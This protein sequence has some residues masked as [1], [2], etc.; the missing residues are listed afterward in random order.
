[1]HLVCLKSRRQ[2]LFRKVGG[3]VL[4]HIRDHRGC[5]RN[6]YTSGWLA[7]GHRALWTRHM[8]TKSKCERPTKTSA[9]SPDLNGWFSK[10]HVKVHILDDI[11]HTLGT[12][13]MQHRSCFS[14]RCVPL[15]DW[16]QRVPSCCLFRDWHEH[17][18]SST[19]FGWSSSSKGTE[20]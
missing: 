4:Q 15:T 2:F 13:M 10:Y 1:M 16:L 3:G 9:T 17:G 18:G 7:Q 5:H 20:Y 11:S 8:E 19:M 14:N 6:E 12:I